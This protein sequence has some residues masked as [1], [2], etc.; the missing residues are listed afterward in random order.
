MENLDARGTAGDVG[1]VY[2]LVGK[3]GYIAKGAAFVIV[4]ALFVAAA[5]TH[6]A[7][8]SGGLD[9][10]LHAVLQQPFGQVLLV[11]IGAGIACYGLFC[12]ARARHL[13]T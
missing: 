11:L 12:F 5:V 3:I 9:N 1:D 4:G 13:S 2:R 8:K 10:A 6:H 7:Q